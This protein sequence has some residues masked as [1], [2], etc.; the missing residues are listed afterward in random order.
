MTTDIYNRLHKRIFLIRQLGEFPVD[1]ALYGNHGT[2][3]NKLHQSLHIVV[4]QA[5]S[6]QRVPIDSGKQVPCM[7]IPENP[8]TPNRIK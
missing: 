4:M 6:L 2:Y 5:Y 1:I 3:G 7:P 8:L